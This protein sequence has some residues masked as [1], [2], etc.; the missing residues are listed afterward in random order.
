MV[1][2]KKVLR[3]HLRKEAAMTTPK[4]STARLSLNEL[5]KMAKAATPGEDGPVSK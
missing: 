4:E 2:W 1:G 3:M 5:E